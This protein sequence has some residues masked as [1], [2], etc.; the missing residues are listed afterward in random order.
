MKVSI[1]I[2]A[3]LLLGSCSSAR[4]TDSWVSEAH[5]EYNPKKVLL[6]GLTDNI[7]GRRLFE[8]Q[9]KKEFINRGV[10]AVE[11]YA[12]FKPTF[13]NSKQ[14]EEEIE[15]EIKRLSNEGFDTVLISAVKGIVEKVNYSGDN[16]RV[17]S[18]WRRF[19]PYYYRYQNIYHLEGYYSKYKVYHIEASMFNLKENNDKSLVWVASYDIVD[20][21]EV[22][23][24]VTN[25]VKAIIKSLEEHQ[26]IDGD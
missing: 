5:K 12:V 22:N 14:T 3:V 23:T 6:I 21:R 8:E 11:S 9:L 24:T 26:L 15:N 13:T 16:F 2:F 4:V 19:G 25:Y 7:T 1:Y 20:P 17:Y 18:N 10:E